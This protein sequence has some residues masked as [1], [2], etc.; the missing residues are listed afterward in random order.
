M[1]ESCV[2][3]GTEELRIKELGGVKKFKDLLEAM[4]ITE[5]GETKP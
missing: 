4:E 3:E 2:I 1:A 5:S